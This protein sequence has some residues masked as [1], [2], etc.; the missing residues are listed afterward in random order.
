MVRTKSGKFAH[1]PSAGKDKAGASHRVLVPADT[2]LSVVAFSSTFSIAD[3][4]GKQDDAKKGLSQDVNIPAS[5]IEKQI[6]LT[7]TGVKGQP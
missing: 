2:D 3:E 4:T 5:S 6:V 7:V 1:V